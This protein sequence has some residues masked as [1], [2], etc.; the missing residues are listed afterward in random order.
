MNRHGRRQA[1]QRKTPEPASLLDALVGHRLLGGCEE[2]VEHRGA[3]VAKSV[4]EAIHQ[5]L[6]GVSLRVN[7]A[8]QL[9]QSISRQLAQQPVEIEAGEVEALKDIE[10]ETDLGEPH[11]ELDE[12]IRHQLGECNLVPGGYDPAGDRHVALEQ[13]MPERRDDFPPAGDGEVEGN[14]GQ[15]AH[16]DSSTSGAA[17]TASGTTVE[18]TRDA[19]G[20]ALEVPGLTAGDRLTGALVALLHCDESPP[21]GSPGFN[22][23][24][25]DNHD[26]RAFAATACQGCRIL[27]QCAD[28]ADLVA[29]ASSKGSLTAAEAAEVLFETDKPTPSE[30]EKARRKLDD[31]TR[32]GLLKVVAQGNRGTATA[33]RW[34]VS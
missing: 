14:F 17:A 8:D 11:L 33:T 22:W 19:V 4:T 2:C 30:R 23:W 6:D 20:D 5:A 34:G 15:I 9:A 7:G 13:R 1:V 32:R 21:C 12:G 24:L 29:L 28:A 16:G 25:S 27:D 10:L 3:Q 31:L 26:D 18:A